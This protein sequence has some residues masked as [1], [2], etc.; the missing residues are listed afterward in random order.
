LEEHQRIRI[1]RVTNQDVFENLEGVI[2]HI[3]NELPPP[4]SS[5]VRKTS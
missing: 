3:L 5:P 1:I 2:T 4:L